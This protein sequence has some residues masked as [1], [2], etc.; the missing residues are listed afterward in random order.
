M[1]N[2]HL[3]FLI[4]I[5]TTNQERT[6]EVLWIFTPQKVFYYLI[7]LDWMDLNFLLSMTMKAL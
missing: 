3:Q 2:I 5:N 6:G 4:Q 7:A 1:Q